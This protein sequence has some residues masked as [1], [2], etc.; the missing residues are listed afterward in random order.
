MNVSDVK[1]YISNLNRVFTGSCHETE[2]SCSHVKVTGRKQLQLFQLDFVFEHLQ[3]LHSQLK[4]SVKR[5]KT[6]T[7]PLG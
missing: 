6:V 7:V 4:S 5:D 2:I 1:N 3:Q